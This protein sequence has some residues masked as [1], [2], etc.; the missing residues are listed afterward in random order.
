MPVHTRGP[1]DSL[2]CKRQP[3]AQAVVEACLALV[4]RVRR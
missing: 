4:E 2:Y 3:P 1:A